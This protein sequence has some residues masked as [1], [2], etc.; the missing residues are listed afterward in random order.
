MPVI[1][2]RIIKKKCF[3]LLT[4]CKSCLTLFL[5]NRCTYSATSTFREK[6]IN[7]FCV[8]TFWYFK[9][10]LGKLSPNF[11]LNRFLQLVNVHMTR[12]RLLTR[13]NLQLVQFN[14]ITV[15]GKMQSKFR[16]QVKW[17]CNKVQQSTRTF[18]LN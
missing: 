4:T 11:Y 3:H 12:K 6:R 1:F 13:A 16:C 14:N 15:I 10:K 8:L 5:V 17:P 9:K 2:I 7:G 18:L